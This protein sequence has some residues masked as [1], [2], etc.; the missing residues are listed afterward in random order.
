MS[1]IRGRDTTPELIVRRAMHATGLRYRLHVKDL[2]GS[3]DIVLPSRRVIV[4]VRGCF[5]H[6]HLGC[7]RAL[8]PATRQEYWVPKLARNRTRDAENEGRLVSAGWHVLVIWE[9]E[10]HDSTKL[11]AFVDG[12]RFYPRGGYHA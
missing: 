1:R 5:W 4:E 6:Q 11:A 12:I 2:P 9:C 10:T 7:S 8:L 3:P